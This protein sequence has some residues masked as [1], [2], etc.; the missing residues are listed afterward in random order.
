MDNYRFSN[1]DYM[2]ALDKL[3][4]Y[5]GKID[6]LGLNTRTF[7]ALK[8]GN[9][10][11]GIFPVH[12]V[13]EL[14]RLTEGT[15]LKM[16]GMG[17]KG[18]GE[19]KD[20]L[21]ERGIGL[22]VKVDF[23]RAFP[24]LVEECGGQGLDALVRMVASD[25]TTARDMGLLAQASALVDQPSVDEGRSVIVLALLNPKNMDVWGQYLAAREEVSRAM[26]GLARARNALLDATNPQ[27]VAEAGRHDVGLMRHMLKN[28][29]GQ[30][31]K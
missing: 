28:L 18:I 22:G 31:P 11:E 2:A 17:R 3:A 27:V 1:P 13:L 15:A 30:S 25:L 16:H 26:E 29:G 8:T 20:K 14:V 9:S 6:E 19:I 21:A 4:P 5:A 7:H 23:S 24:A 10:T 12:F